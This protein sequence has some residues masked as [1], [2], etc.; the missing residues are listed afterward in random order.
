MNPEDLAIGARLAA[1]ERTEVLAERAR[2]MMG[3]GGVGRG[4]MQTKK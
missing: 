4:E 2:C 3:K 1:A